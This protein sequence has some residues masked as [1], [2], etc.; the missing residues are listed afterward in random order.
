M[1]SHKNVPCLRR[2][3]I[4]H[5]MEISWSIVVDTVVAYIHPQNL[6]TELELALG[7]MITFKC[8]KLFQTIGNRITSADR[9]LRH[10]RWLSLQ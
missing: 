10:I 2:S 9:G 5:R 6:T 8:N 7:A 4:V 3:R 1:I